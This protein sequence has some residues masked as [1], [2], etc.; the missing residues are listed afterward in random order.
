MNPYPQ[1]VA[2]TEPSKFFGR[3]NEL[4]IIFENINRSSNLSI[5]GARRFGKSSLRNIAIHPDTRGKYS[6]SPDC[7]LVA[8]SFRS[9]RAQNPA[10]FFHT[11]RTSAWNAARLAGTPEPS[12]PFP[13]GALSLTEEQD[14]LSEL[15]FHLCKI[16]KNTCFLLDEAERLFLSSGLTSA[17]FDFLRQ[18]ADNDA[19]NRRACFIV[20]SRRALKEISKEAEASPFF[21]VFGRTIWLKNLDDAAALRLITEPCLGQEISLEPYAAD[22]IRV[23]GRQPLIL[24]CA[25]ACAFETLRNG[26]ALDP[27]T[28][29]QELYF[30]V[31]GYLEDWWASLHPV[32]C[33]ALRAV[34]LGLPTA[35]GW[36]NWLD[37]SRQTG[38]LDQIDGWQSISPPIFKPFIQRLQA[39]SPAK[40]LAMDSAMLAP[41]GPD[42][43]ELFRTVTSDLITALRYVLSTT[44]D[45]YLGNRSSWRLETMQPVLYHTLRQFGYFDCESDPIDS[46]HLTELLSLIE[47]GWDLFSDYLTPTMQDRIGPLDFWG[48]RVASIQKMIETLRT[49]EGCSLSAIQSASKSVAELLEVIRDGGTRQ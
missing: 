18:L 4:R 36:H 27:K 15:L 22:I 14:L 6:L 44:L 48:S 29:Q 10:E 17:E 39:H 41:A 21:N 49:K 33:Q 30:S 45:Y 20:F 46:M 43:I 40:A 2:I 9:Y 35:E 25:C 1:S 26:S 32:C 24:Q 34:C 13:E 19:G 42:D 28:F 23:A 5:V 37:W 3:E 38:W 47:S 7:L 8:P 16:G 31:E 12:F 11:L